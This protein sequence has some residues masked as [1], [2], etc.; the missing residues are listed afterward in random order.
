MP[1]SEAPRPPALAAW[2]EGPLVVGIGAAAALACLPSIAVASDGHER[3]LAA[4]LTGVALVLPIGVLASLRRMRSLHTALLVGG[5]A[6]AVL[7]LS[8]ASPPD[9]ASVVLGFCFLLQLHRTPRTPRDVRALLVTTLGLLAVGLASASEQNTP[10]RVSVSFAWAVAA[11]VVLHLAARPDLTEPV[12]PRHAAPLVTRRAVLSIVAILG[13]AGLA[14]LLVPAPPLH[15]LARGV[16]G[17]GGPGPSS[18]GA[19]A[20]GGSTASGPIPSDGGSPLDLRVRGSLPSTP[21]A[22]VFGAPG[23]SLLRNGVYD[24]Y[25][26]QVWTETGTI[27]NDD[28]APGPVTTIDVHLLQPMRTVLSAGRLVAASGPW[29]RLVDLVGTWM[30]IPGVPVG[31]T[32]ATRG[33]SPGA[34]GGPQAPAEAAT[35]ALPDEL[36]TRVRDLATTW[37][38]GATTVDAKVRAIEQHL[39]TTMTYTLKAPVPSPGHD[40]VDDLLFNTHEGFCEQFASAEAVLLR[41]LGIPTRLV[42]G[43][44]MAGG[45]NDTASAGAGTQILGSDAH[46][47]VDVWHPGRGW[48]ESDPTAGIP[49]AAESAGGAAHTVLLAALLVL[50]GLGLLAVPAVLLRR[51]RVRRADEAARPPVIAAYLE[52]L[53]ALDRAGRA[54]PPGL[55]P[56]E[57]LATVPG[58]VPRTAIAVLEQELWSDAALPDHV[59][60]RAR[61]ELVGVASGIDAAAKG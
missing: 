13:V 14:G 2:A 41:T 57:V 1:S 20:S 5:G 22:V 23:G 6:L 46:A 25:D 39:R 50:L 34:S 54:A 16:V 24:T 7:A 21:V 27:A 38:A 28:G 29:N 58:G 35:T 47:W 9:A 31:E 30:P 10:F 43:Y 52:V 44:A 53:D 59:R 12:T 48:V 11:G 18:S 40:A 36:P 55:T 37:T 26:G 51:R 3:A 19:G 42:V 45:A 61:E 15:G 60:A 32:Y 4:A 33:T 49:L 56:R 8:S 17:R